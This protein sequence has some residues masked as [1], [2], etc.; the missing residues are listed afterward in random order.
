MCDVQSAAAS[1]APVHCFIRNRMRDPQAARALGY[2]ND[3]NATSSSSSFAAH[4]R[5]QEY[6]DKES[7][8]P[9]YYN[10]VSKETQWD[11]P[12][13]YEDAFAQRRDLDVVTP[14]R[15][16]A[17]LVAEALRAV[18]SCEL[19]PALRVHVREVR[20]VDGYPNHEAPDITDVPPDA[21][22][23][24]YEVIVVPTVGDLTRRTTSISRVG[25]KPSEI[26]FGSGR[27]ML[28]GFDQSWQRRR[29]SNTIYPGQSWQRRHAGE[30]PPAAAVKVADVSV[31]K[32][33]AQY[34]GG[35]SGADVAAR[36]VS[37]ARGQLQSICASSAIRGLQLKLL[38][39]TTGDY[40]QYRQTTS[41]RGLQRS[42]GRSE[43]LLPRGRDKRW[44]RWQLQNKAASALL[45]LKRWQAEQRLATA[46]LLHT[47]LAS[48]GSLCSDIH[49]EIARR[50]EHTTE[51]A[52]AASSRHAA[53][54]TQTST[55]AQ[56]LRTHTEIQR[57][58][59]E[60]LPF[61]FTG[62]YASTAAALGLQLPHVRSGDA[63]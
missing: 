30:A 14:T 55:P 37:A 9:Y 35:V 41:L 34:L 61:G 39:A 15:G 4:G 24:G 63:S 13:D 5:W 49:E 45:G 33:F 23:G 62:S 26:L 27:E 44:Q 25:D 40:R 28:F 58:Q 32:D 51:A 16:E 10:L 17:K 22:R 36:L 43:F 2:Q 52:V 31:R 11:R 46:K 50:V 12:A 20:L 48:V 1:H 47:R 60:L 59:Q 42:R 29:F 18:L 6:M 7:G 56:L 38:Q 21:Q 8:N 3:S 54:A 19:P 57:L 53:L